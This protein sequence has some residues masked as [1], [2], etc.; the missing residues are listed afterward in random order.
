M[1]SFKGAIASSAEGSLQELK[2]VL[3]AISSRHHLSAHLK[4]ALDGVPKSRDQ[5]VRVYLETDVN[6]IIMCICV[7][8]CRN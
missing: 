6:T 4:T 7:S 1:G 3:Q 2:K 5:K 8:G